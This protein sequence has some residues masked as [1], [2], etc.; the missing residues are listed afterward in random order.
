MLGCCFSTKHVQTHTPTAWHTLHCFIPLTFTAVGNIL[1]IVCLEY[2]ASSKLL[3]PLEPFLQ[4]IDLGRKNIL[5]DSLKYTLYLCSICP[6]SVR[7]MLLL[8]SQTHSPSSPP[9]SNHTFLSDG[10]LTRLHSHIIGPDSPPD[11]NLSSSRHHYHQRTSY[12]KQYIECLCDGVVFQHQ[13]SIPMNRWF[14]GVNGNFLKF[15]NDS[16]HIYAPIIGSH[17]YA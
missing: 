14:L 6:H 4:S 17:S 10:K 9:H 2:D 3:T 15:I 1:E 16:S 12:I 8:N 5:S 11:C 7:F 13:Q